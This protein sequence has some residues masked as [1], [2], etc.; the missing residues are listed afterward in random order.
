MPVSPVSSALGLSVSDGTGSSFWGHPHKSTQM[1]A[2]TVL[3][4]PGQH[5]TTRPTTD[6][7]DDTEGDCACCCTCEGFSVVLTSGAPSRST[8]PDPPTSART[9]EAVC[10]GLCS[11]TQRFCG[12][13]IQD[14]VGGA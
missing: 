10:C 5:S 1:A 13:Q 11:Q 14:A 8:A 7:A 3:T 12:R 2:L 4:L 6:S 9:R